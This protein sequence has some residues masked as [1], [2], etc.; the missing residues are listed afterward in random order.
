MIE[1]KD[2]EE[3]ILKELAN[4]TPEEKERYRRYLKTGDIDVLCE[5]GDWEP[6]EDWEPRE[7]D[8]V[9]VRGPPS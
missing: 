4:M 5:P 7:E 6:P 1:P 9:I 8:G 3:E 2:L